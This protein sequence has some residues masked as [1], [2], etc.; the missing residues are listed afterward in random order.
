LNVDKFS[1]FKDDAGRVGCRSAPRKA[2]RE[3]PMQARDVHDQVGSWFGMIV[4]GHLLELIRSGVPFWW[5]LQMVPNMSEIFEDCQ[6]IWVLPAVHYLSHCPVMRVGPA[7][8]L[9]LGCL[10]ECDHGLPP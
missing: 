8:A 2:F 3:M 5:A 4:Q 10:A 6:Q 7:F 9:V 1:Y